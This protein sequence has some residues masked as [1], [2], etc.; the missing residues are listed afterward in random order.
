M[1]NVLGSALS[2]LPPIKLL[3]GV[4]LGLI[5]ACL[6]LVFVFGPVPDPVAAA[7]RELPPFL[8]ATV[9]DMVVP[10]P[11]STMKSQSL[12]L[13]AAGTLT[14]RASGSDAGAFNLYLIRVQADLLP[15]RAREFALMSE[16]T[17]EGVRSYARQAPVEKG[18]YLV[19]LINAAA[20]NERPD[21]VLTIHAR[22]DP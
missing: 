10:L 5:A 12:V 20:R 2:Q 4:L 19:T 9:A 18:V 1:K 13:P 8:P 17:A 6:G 22:L 11:N 7:A 16:F 21:P 3:E 14:L 15:G